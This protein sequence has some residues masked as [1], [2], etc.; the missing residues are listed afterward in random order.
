MSLRSFAAGY[1][2]FHPHRVLGWHAYDR[3]TRRPHWDDHP[4]WIERNRRSM[5]L[6]GAAYR[7]TARIGASDATVADFERYAGVELASR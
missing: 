3:A 5:E 7:S 2:F 1:R 4:D 6:L